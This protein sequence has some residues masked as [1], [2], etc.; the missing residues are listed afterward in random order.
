MDSTSPG[1]ATYIHINQALTGLDKVRDALALKIKGELAA[2]AFS[3]TP[4]PG[5]GVQI[6]ACQ[7]HHQGRPAPGGHQL[8]AAHRVL[9]A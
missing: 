1:D 7:G 2:A 8:T 3:D 6:A 9:T 5:A 4:V